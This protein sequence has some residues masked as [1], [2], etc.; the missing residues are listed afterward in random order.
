MVSLAKPKS[1]SLSRALG[2]FEEYS[3]FSGCREDSGSKP[4]ENE[5]YDISYYSYLSHPLNPPLRFLECLYKEHRN[6]LLNSAL[7]ACCDTNLDIS[8]CNIDCMQ[9]L[10]GLSYA[11]HDIRCL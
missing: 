9:K 1:V 2:L 5:E 6:F 11:L 10:D 7:I 4:E 3:K 8:V